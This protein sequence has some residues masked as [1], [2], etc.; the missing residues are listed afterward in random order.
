MQDRFVTS[1]AKSLVTTIYRIR[2]W[3]SDLQPGTAAAIVRR[4]PLMSGVMLVGGKNVDTIDLELDRT[5]RGPD[6]RSHPA[7][8]DRYAFHGSK[9]G[10][11]V[12]QIRP[13]NETAVV[14]L[15]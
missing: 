4:T 9:G 15:N 12:D 7:V 13:G 14:D 3:L 2:S 5:G 10:A 8:A 6:G 1:P 11:F